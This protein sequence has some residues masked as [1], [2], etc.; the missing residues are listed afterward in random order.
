M[1]VCM[2]ACLLY[3]KFPQVNNPP[4]ICD[5]IFEQSSNEGERQHFV[6]SSQTK[7]THTHKHLASEGVNGFAAERQGAGKYK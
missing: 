6:P 4:A 3:K 5:M 7:K 2:C 1:C